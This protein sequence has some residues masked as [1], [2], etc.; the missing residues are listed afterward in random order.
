MTC[1]TKLHSTQ[2][3]IGTLIYV[4]QFGFNLAIVV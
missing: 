2:K 1:Q 4:S 3:Q